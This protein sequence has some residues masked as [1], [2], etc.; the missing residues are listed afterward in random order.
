MIS[1]TKAQLSYNKSHW[2]RNCQPSSQK[3]A[4]M[5]Q[6]LSILILT[7]PHFQVAILDGQLT[8]Q[9]LRSPHLLV[10][11]HFSEFG[12]KIEALSDS[13]SGEVSR[14]QVS[15]LQLPECRWN[16]DNLIT[17]RKTKNFYIKLQ[18]LKNVLYL[19]AKVYVLQ[20][21]SKSHRSFGI[22]L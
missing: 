12:R 14:F 19:R 21:F 9:S 1:P 22:K 3:N 10:V 20:F 13:I 17:S 11:Q 4:D 2:L 6:Q 8:A 18:P 7:L 16:K 5:E 15:R